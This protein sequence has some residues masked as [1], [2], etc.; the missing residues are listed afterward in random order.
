M[1]DA[2]KITIRKQMHMTITI[3]LWFYIKFHISTIDNLYKKSC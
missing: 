1:R 2:L 3:G